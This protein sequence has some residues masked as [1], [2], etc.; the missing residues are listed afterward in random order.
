MKG[1]G[2]RA[3]V[4]YGHVVDWNVEFFLDFSVSTGD[5]NTP[6]DMIQLTF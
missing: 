4:I 1:W 6:S 3:Q 2:V 5:F